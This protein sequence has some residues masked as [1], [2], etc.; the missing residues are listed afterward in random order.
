[1]TSW[2]GILFGVLAA[3]MWGTSGPMMRMA[4]SLDI[5]V[6]LLN[7]VRFTVSSATLILFALYRHPEA[8]KPSRSDIS[9][10][11]LLGACGM[12]MSA[13]GLNFAFLHITVGLA[14][15]VY[16]SAPCWVMA[17]SWILGRDRPVKGEVGAF[18][19]ALAGVWV[20]VG[21]AGSMGTLSLAGLAGA[22][23]GAVGYALFVLNGKYGTGPRAPFRSFFYTYIAAML[24]LWVMAFARGDMGMLMH[25]SARGWL[26]LLYLAFFTSLVPYG[27]FVLALKRVQGS[28]AS[29][30]TMTEVPFAMMWA[31]LISSERP[32]TSAVLGGALVLLGVAALAL[33]RPARGDYAGQK[34][35]KAVL[36]EKRDM[37]T[38]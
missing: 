26:I 31:W 6:F 20:A 2:S 36:T 14:M 25:I 34:A 21:G 8:L 17:G 3:L 30:A 15:V 35:S 7:V 37:H 11:F 27:V 4:D 32:E 38:L 9:P 5:S 33:A 18:A 29:I 12:V 23:A 1:M 10:L 28:T 13:V 16:Y 24:I 22:L 19:L